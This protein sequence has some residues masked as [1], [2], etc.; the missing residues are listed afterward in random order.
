MK[1]ICFSAIVVLLAF[2][3][4]LSGC[5]GNTDK[6]PVNAEEKPNEETVLSSV[7][8]PKKVTEYNTFEFVGNDKYNGRNYL[9]TISVPKGM[10]SVPPSS[11]LSVGGVAGFSEVL[12]YTEETKY[13]CELQIM[14]ATDKTM[15]EMLEKA[16][17]NYEMFDSLYY[18]LYDNGILEKKDPGIDWA[19]ETTRYFDCGYTL[20][21]FFS[22]ECGYEKMIY[23][24]LSTAD[25]SVTD[26]EAS[27]IKQITGSEARRGT[28]SEKYN[29]YEVSYKRPSNGDEYDILFSLPDGVHYTVNQWGEPKFDDKLCNVTLLDGTGYSKDG[30]ML[31]FINIGPFSSDEHDLSDTYKYTELE[32]GI[33]TYEYTPVV[34]GGGAYPHRV[35]FMVLDDKYMVYID[36]TIAPYCEIGELEKRISFDFFNTLKISKK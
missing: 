2:T 10:K 28:P 3:M 25:L 1:R 9:L 4:L 17:R 27:A 16:K 33:Y 24:M 23:D 26:R 21:A 7:I 13:F 29:E 5:K 6:P 8:L 35:Y 22:N 15:D 11:G 30:N 34:E 12:T 14:P 18:K 32:D 20:T 19:V 36:E 31:S